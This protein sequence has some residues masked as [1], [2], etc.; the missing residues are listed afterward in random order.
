MDKIRKSLMELGYEFWDDEAIDGMSKYLR[1]L[2]LKNKEQY[3][4]RN[5]IMCFFDRWANSGVEHMFETE[6]EVIKYFTDPTKCLAEAVEELIISIIESA[7]W[8]KDYSK[9]DKMIDFLMDLIEEENMTKNV[10]VT[11]NIEIARK[12]L[13]MAGFK[14]VDNMTDDEVFKQALKM[15][16]EYG[17]TSVIK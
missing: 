12:A 6:D 2:V 7:E 5:A 11:V 9:V 16:E 17:V 4:V 14:S 8:D 10:E 13:I 15:N 3:L 1:I